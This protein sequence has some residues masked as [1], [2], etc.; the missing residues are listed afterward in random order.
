MIRRLA[1]VI[2]F[3]KKKY[4]K[5][6]LESLANQ[7]NKNF[8]IYI[9]NDNSPENIE[10]LLQEFLPALNLIYEKFETNLG[11]NFLTKQWDRCIS[12]SRNEDWLMILGDDDVLQDNFVEEF[13]KNLEK[14]ELAHCKVIRFASQNINEKGETISPIYKN[15]EVEPA[16]TSFLKLLTGNH[17]SSLTEHIFHRSAYEKHGFVHFPV[18]FGSDNIA[19]LEFSELKNIFSINS[20]VAYIRIS[21][22]HL[23]SKIDSQLDIKRKQ[24]IYQFHR[25][26][27]KHYASSFSINDKIKIL[28]KAYSHLRQSDRSTL[29]LLNFVGFLFSKIGVNNTIK[30]L[31][32]NRNK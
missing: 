18:A 24:G 10:D 5:K 31:K 9:G 27:I 13:Y 17:R 2:P 28:K 30:I 22:E 8:N 15:P 7:T 19:W 21:P 23:S 26:I 12:L 11:A 25:Y 4:F 6:T 14:V 29:K 20:S 32:E 16:P 1:I 3:Y